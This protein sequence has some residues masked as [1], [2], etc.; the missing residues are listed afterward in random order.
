MC[1][2]SCLIP[3]LCIPLQC[4][5]NKFCVDNKHFALV[6]CDDGAIRETKIYGPGFDLSF[7]HKASYFIYV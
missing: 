5:T 1:M 6:T 7:L 4:M 2:V 3:P